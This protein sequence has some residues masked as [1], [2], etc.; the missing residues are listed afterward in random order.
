MFHYWYI[1]QVE[2]HILVTV[3]D[4]VQQCD[5][6]PSEYGAE[7]TVSIHCK[8]ILETE[9]IKYQHGFDVR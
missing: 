8:D 7:D 6:F 3:D 2:F 1:G 5:K 4:D 9:N